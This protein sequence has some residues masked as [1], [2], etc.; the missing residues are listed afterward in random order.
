MCRV[1]LLVTFDLELSPQGQ[2]SDFTVTNCHL[3]GQLQIL[4]YSINFYHEKWAFGASSRTCGKS[5]TSVFCQSVNFSHF[6][7]LLWNHLMNWYYLIHKYNTKSSRAKLGDTGKKS[8]IDL[9]LYTFQMNQL[10][11]KVFYYWS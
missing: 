1:P 7:L 2:I 10:S 4:L 9:E 11:P 6:H 3:V 5:K 8:T